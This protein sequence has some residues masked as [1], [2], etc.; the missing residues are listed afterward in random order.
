M[1]RRGLLGLPSA[2]AAPLRLLVLLALLPVTRAIY[3]LEM[4]R[5]PSEAVAGLPFGVQP[6]VALY[7]DDGLLAASYVGFCSTLG[8]VTPTGTEQV[9]RNGTAGQDATRVQ[10]VDGYA[11]FDGLYINVAGLYAVSYTHLTLPTTPYV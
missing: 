6:A 7:D 3:T 4:F 9:L 8:Y 2:L 1:R 11:V 5:Q 10:F